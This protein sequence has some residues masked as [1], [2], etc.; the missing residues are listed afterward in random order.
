MAASIEDIKDMYRRGEQQG[1]T[2]MIIATDWFDYEDYPIY[3][4]PGE[5]P[6]E[7]AK[8]AGKDKIMEC[9]RFALGWASQAAEDRANHWEI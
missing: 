1:A 3:V 2:H 7:K 6:R 9:Y 5:D 4:M 8:E